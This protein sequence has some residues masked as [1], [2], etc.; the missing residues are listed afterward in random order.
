MEL[1]A[2]V[3]DSAGAVQCSPTAREIDSIVVVLYVGLVF[4]NKDFEKSGQ[5][6]DGIWENE[7]AK[8]PSRTATSFVD[9]AISSAE[10]APKA[11]VPLSSNKSFVHPLRPG[12][13][14]A[15]SKIM[16]HVNWM[17]QKTLGGNFHSFLHGTQPEFV[18]TEFFSTLID[19][20]HNLPT[21]GRFHI[22]P[23]PPMKI[24]NALPQTK[25]GWPSWDRR[26]QL[27]YINSETIGV[28]LLCDRLESSGGGSRVKA[29]ARRRRSIKGKKRKNIRE[30]EKGKR[31]V[32]VMIGPSNVVQVITDN[33]PV[34]YNRKKVRSRR[35]EETPRRGDIM[36]ERIP[37]GG[38]GQSSQ[39]V[40]IFEDSENVVPVRGSAPNVD[41]AS[42]GMD[43]MNAMSVNMMQLQMMNMMME[44]MQ[45]IIR[46]DGFL[47][48][49]ILGA[50]AIIV[51]LLSVKMK[52]RSSVLA[53][54]YRLLCGVE[55]QWGEGGKENL[56]L[57]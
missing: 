12:F 2:T 26:K 8:V 31:E 38:E 47:S 35:L 34:T 28:A 18:N 9:S 13:G 52:V 10:K 53:L 27:S 19:Y 30:K 11:V 46:D 44:K 3:H 40:R 39:P 41:P 51:Q 33:A 50:S 54:A 6:H 29:K 21:V 4:F 1:A 57:R 15:G 16:I 42:V 48:H 49:Y 55:D 17:F 5:I 24:E 23:K 7:A 14:S 56:W 36:T 22:I 45:S 37:E 43:A 20:L 25:K 32:I